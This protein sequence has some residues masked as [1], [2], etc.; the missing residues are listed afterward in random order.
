MASLNVVHIMGYLGKDPEVRTTQSGTKI[1]SMNIATSKVWQDKNT[2][3]RKERSQWH[4]VVIMSEVLAGT[5]EKFLRKG[6]QAYVEGELQTRTYT[7]QDNVERQITEIIVGRFDGK[8]LLVGRPPNGD[9]QQ[10]APS[11][12]APSRQG[13]AP[14]QHQQH[15]QHQGGLA[16]AHGG[17]W[18]AGGWDGDP[19]DIPF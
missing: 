1:V 18:D 11:N 9:G 14:Q 8:L 13:H 12:S 4:R 5:A 2:G 19:S 17:G 3:E 15:Q 10:P 16:P 6:S 7:G